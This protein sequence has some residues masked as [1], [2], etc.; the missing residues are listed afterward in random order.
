MSADLLAAFGERNATGQWDQ[1]SQKSPHENDRASRF[2]DPDNNNTGCG[3]WGSFLST[4]RDAR[5]ANKSNSEQGFCARMPTPDLKPAQVVSTSSKNL[6]RVESGTDVLFDA[7]TEDIKNDDETDEWGEFET[8]NP[9]EVDSNSGNADN[10]LS[11]DTRNDTA[12]NMASSATEST[13]AKFHQ[14]SLLDLLPPNV[15]TDD[16]G[17]IEV[18]AADVS[19]WDN[20]WTKFEES[21]GSNIVPSKSEQS[22]DDDWGD[23]ADATWTANTTPAIFLEP[24]RPDVAL[25]ETTTAEVN[26]PVFMQP[27]TTPMVSTKSNTFQH[28]PMNIPPPSILLPLFPPLLEQY[29]QE[30]VK[31]KQVGPKDPKLVSSLENDLKVMARILAGRT[32]RWKRDTVLSQSM[33]IGPANSG[34]AGG[35][36]LNSVNKSENVKEEKEAVEV[37]EAWQKRSSYLNSFL[38]S[39][40]GRAVPVLPKNVQVKTGTV[41]EDGAFKASHACGLCGLKR[42]ERIPKV[43]GIVHDNFGEWWIELWGHTDCRNFWEANCD[44]LNQR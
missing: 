10:L 42:D 25:L 36:K 7:S 44:R 1:S 12:L 32:L 39:A 24:S 28:R 27:P 15:E 13:T 17:A 21:S 6:W 2:F 34:K 9:P 41:E 5:A 16:K 18:A 23:F 19:L 43:D 22:D 8:A 20:A 33:K 11:W 35:M 30:S 38:L 31:C 14:Q 3:A 26:Q 40:G 4:S 29:Y 37:L